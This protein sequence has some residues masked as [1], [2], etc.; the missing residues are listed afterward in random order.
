MAG[1]G[2]QNQAPMELRDNPQCRER[3]KITSH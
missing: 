3:C 1:Q 2:E